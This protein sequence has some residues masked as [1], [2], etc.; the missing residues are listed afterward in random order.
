MLV[1][2]HRVMTEDAWGLHGMVVV[3]KEDAS[4]VVPGCLPSSLELSIG[5]L[6]MEDKDGCRCQRQ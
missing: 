2:A 5:L 6:R 3:D 1:S 4:I